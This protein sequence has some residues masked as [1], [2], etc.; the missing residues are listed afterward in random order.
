MCISHKVFKLCIKIFGMIVLKKTGRH[1]TSSFWIRT[2]MGFSFFPRFLNLLNVKLYKLF[3][4]FGQMCT[5][6]LTREGQSGLKSALFEVHF[7][8]LKRNI[9]NEKIFG[10]HSPDLNKKLNW[11]RNVLINIY[12]FFKGII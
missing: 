9:L 7:R 5:F 8:F 6:A 11:S 2:F 12:N 1:I 4:L 3:K 10:Y